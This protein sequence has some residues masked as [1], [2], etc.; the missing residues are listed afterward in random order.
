V[1]YRCCDALRRS[2]LGVTGFNGID[3]LE[4]R[5]GDLLVHF[6]NGR[7]LDAVTPRNIRIEGGER[8]RR[9]RAIDAQKEPGAANV[10]RVT[11]SEQGDFSRYLLRLVRS[12]DGR[13]PTGFDPAL[14]AVDFSFRIECGAEFDCRTPSACTPDL[15]DEPRIDYLAKDY[16]SFR[17]LMLDRMSV[18]VPQWRDR[19]AADAGMTLI[20][21]LAYAGDSLSY[22]QDAIATE[23]YLHTARR[24]TSVRRHARLVDYPMHDGCN[25]RVWVHIAVEGRAV[26]LPA[27]TALLT[28]CEGQPSRIA[29]NSDEHRRALDSD[30]TVFE[31][32]HNGLLFASHNELTFHTWS[33]ERCCLPRGAT[34]ATLRDGTDADSRLRLCVGDVLVFEESYG[35]E[36]GHPADANPAHRHAVRLTRVEP[37]AIRKIEQQQEV[38]RT[39]GPV[40][41]DPVTAQPVV[42]IEWEPADGLPFPLCLWEVD[43]PHGRRPVSRGLGN[44]VLADHGRRIAPAEDLG[45]VPPAV[46]SRRNT[47]ASSYCDRPAAAASPPRYRPRLGRGPLTHTVPYDASLPA[48]A[49]LRARPSEAKP[50]LTLFSPGATW[51]PRPDLLA[52]GPHD[53]DIVV[54]VE[55][56]GTAFLRFG[57]GRHAVRAEAGTPFSAEYRIGN[58]VAGNVGAHSIGH[59]VTDLAPVT[60]VT[61]PLPAQ[62]GTDPESLESV[63]ESAPVAFRSQQRA[64]TRGDYETLSGQFVGVQRAAATFL[65]T[66]SWHTAFVSVDRAGGLLVDDEFERK[67]R[68]HLEPY[69]LAGYD[70]EVDNPTTVPLEIDM[71]VCVKPGYFRADVKAALMEVFSS[72][73]LANERRGVFHP[74]NFSFGQP[75]FLSPL[76]AAAQEIAGVASVAITRFQR[77]GVPDSEPLTTGRLLLG[78]LEIATLANDPTFPDRGIFRLTLGGGK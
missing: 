17:R 78:R 38:D 62:G 60:A 29:A 56:D 49:Q 37:E 20:E 7:H 48:A 26:P 65:W 9:I 39:R 34:R 54:E 4:I 74:D 52:S 46:V 55:W 3:Y 10:L 18:L 25:A 42:E 68:A 59:V 40:R 69:R 33:D 73:T 12:D 14:A 27:G 67:L 23:A 57:D 51:T 41:T 58:G 13:P 30:P 47:T 2:E 66:G 28:T 75:V 71:Q 31:T 36:T 77:M 1:I 24:R 76:Y 35:P 70:L 19:G 43:T 45:R 15:R 21:L 16:A 22:Y 61:N 63:R 44:I 32:T 64:V 5:E 6:V 50:V 53:R 72:H 8:I 11:V